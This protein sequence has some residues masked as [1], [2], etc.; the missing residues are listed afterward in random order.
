[1]LISK[2]GFAFF[3]KDMKINKYINNLKMSKEYKELITERLNVEGLFKEYNELKA[4]YQ[5]EMNTSYFNQ[6]KKVVMPS[7]V[8][9]RELLDRKL[10]LV[11]NTIK[12]WFLGIRA[13]RKLR[14]EV[15]INVL[16][17]KTKEF[18]EGDC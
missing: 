3:I 16:N 13:A 17:S 6:D 18:N 10:I 5:K 9:H 14:L 1:M 4:E 8:I 7:S 2:E 11:E 12:K 15:D